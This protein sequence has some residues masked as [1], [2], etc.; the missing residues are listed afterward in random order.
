MNSNQSEIKKPFQGIANG[1]NRKHPLFA[2]GMLV[3]TPGALALLER[4]Q[5][6]A[7][8]LL[9]RHITGDFGDL[10]SEDIKSN[11]DAVQDGGRIFSSYVL[12]GEKVW[13]I[14]EACDDRGTRAVT[15]LLLPHEY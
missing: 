6:P 3:A 12:E 11:N 13:L 8:E 2:L 14:T 7:S 4:L 1:L 10:C 9:Q 5:K 15:T